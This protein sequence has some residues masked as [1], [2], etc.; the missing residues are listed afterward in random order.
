MDLHSSTLSLGSMVTKA[1]LPAGLLVNMWASHSDSVDVWKSVNDYIDNIPYVVKHPHPGALF[2]IFLLESSKI[3]YFAL[4]SIWWWQYCSVWVRWWRNEHKVK[5][6][7]QRNFLKARRILSHWL[8]L[9]F[10]IESKV[11][12]A[13]TLQGKDR[14]SMYW[15]VKVSSPI[16]TTRLEITLLITNPSG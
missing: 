3:I 13:S 2:V 9:L 15:L 1:S 7:G 12:Q 14:A 10:I 6:S 8:G 4:S 11:E 5:W 16:Q